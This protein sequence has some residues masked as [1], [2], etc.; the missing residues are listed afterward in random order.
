MSRR[1]FLAAMLFVVSLAGC[2]KDRPGPTDPNSTGGPTNSDPIPNGNWPDPDGTV[3]TVQPVDST[4]YTPTDTLGVSI[5][6]STTPLL[7]QTSGAARYNLGSCSAKGTWTAP[8]GTSY[9]PHNP[10][11]LSYRTSGQGSNGK[12]HCVMSSQGYPGLWINA[13]GHGTSPYSPKCLER[14]TPSTTLA[15]TFSV[16]AELFQ[17]TDGSG[18]SMLNFT[19]GGVI[20]AQLI[21]HGTAADSTTGAGVLLGTD[22]SSPAQVWSIGFGQP[23]LNYT[24][25]AANGDLITA[26][27]TTGVEV[28]AC[29]AAVGCSTITLKIGG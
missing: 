4:V 13:V 17:A 3:P 2:N 21:Y 19:S 28:I 23:A 11:C 9:G 16:Q 5:G 8:N 25:G 20:Q 10:N 7:F 18:G 15:L 26:L 22:N 29:N 14:G 12:G 6:D 27:S 24:G 1:L